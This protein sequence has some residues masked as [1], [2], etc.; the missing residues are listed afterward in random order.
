[1]PLTCNKVLHRG[2]LMSFREEQPPPRPS[3]PRGE[4]RPGLQGYL[5]LSKEC[6]MLPVRQA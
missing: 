3:R 5:L 1:M 2:Y 6:P 4:P